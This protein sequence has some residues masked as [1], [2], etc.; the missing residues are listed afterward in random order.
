MKI[1]AD[2]GE[3][4]NVFHDS[5]VIEL[6][7]EQIKHG[8]VPDGRYHPGEAGESSDES[9]ITQ[10]MMTWVDAANMPAEGLTH[11]I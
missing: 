3:P 5:N 4:M 6:P 1:V 11:L 9:L 8:N 10:A 2:G 7:M